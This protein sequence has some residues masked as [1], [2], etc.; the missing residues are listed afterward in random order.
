MSNSKQSRATF[1]ATDSNIEKIAAS[2]GGVAIQSSAFGLFYIINPDDK[3]RIGIVAN[4]RLVL[5]K[6]QLRALMK[7]LPDILDQHFGRKP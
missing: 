3:N 7:D 6:T 4:G 2:A 1:K 5:T